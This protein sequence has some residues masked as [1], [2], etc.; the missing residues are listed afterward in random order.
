MTPAEI[1][2]RALALSQARDKAALAADALQEISEVE[3][4]PEI[5]RNCAERTRMAVMVMVRR[6]GEERDRVRGRGVNVDRG[7]A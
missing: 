5:D 6:L 3:G 1:E 4:V 7:A 2:A